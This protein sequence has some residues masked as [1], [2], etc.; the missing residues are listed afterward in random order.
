MPLVEKPGFLGTATELVPL[1]Y[2]FAVPAAAR[3]V[4][5]PGLVFIGYNLFHALYDIVFQPQS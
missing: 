4:F 1:W 5:D 3:S 2:R